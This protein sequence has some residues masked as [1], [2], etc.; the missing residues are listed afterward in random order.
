MRSRA[1]LLGSALLLAVAAPISAG[2]QSAPGLGNND[3]HCNGGRGFHYT[4]PW[5]SVE[6]LG[7][8]VTSRGVTLIDY[9]SANPSTENPLGEYT[10]LA[11]SRGCTLDRRFGTDGV[12]RPRL[13][14]GGLHRGFG[15]GGSVVPAS[16]GGFFVLVSGAHDSWL[17]E[18]NARGGLVRR[19]G[20]RGWAHL[21]ERPGLFGDKSITDAYQAPSGLI[22]VGGDQGASHATT[23]VFVMALRPDGRLDTAFGTDGVVHVLPR[24]TEGGGLLVQPDRSIAVVGWLGGGGCGDDQIAWLTPSGRHERAVDAAYDRGG[25]FPLTSCF[26]GDE[27]VDA[28]GGVGAVGV[29]TSIPG[30]RGSGPPLSA[31]EGLTPSAQPDP[32]FGSG[33]LTRFST[34]SESSW[35]NS[36]ATLGDGDV[37]YASTGSRYVYL[38]AFSSRGHLYRDLGRRGHARLKCVATTPSY[39][40]LCTSSGVVA[41]PRPDDATIALGVGRHVAL[42]ELIA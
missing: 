21:P 16:H 17:G 14:D 41:G 30:V 37:A 13:P 11:V 39:T 38:Q 34:P 15:V 40:S 35:Q 2:A 27:F 33:G 1:A 18:F 5:Y 12:L 9:T 25:T 19:F 22:Y 32:A 3:P 42:F 28:A 6:S 4:S 29:V 7:V 36:A 8:A 10:I 20:H 31:I 26:W 23:R 24:M